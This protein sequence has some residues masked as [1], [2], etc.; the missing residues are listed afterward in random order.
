MLLSIFPLKTYFDSDSE[1]CRT[2]MAMSICTHSFFLFCL[3]LNRVESKNGT[4]SQ[5]FPVPEDPQST[6]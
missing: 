5:Q 1:F 2:G 6:F 4:C 3:S